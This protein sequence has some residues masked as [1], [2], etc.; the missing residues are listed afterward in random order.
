MG[1]S[2]PQVQQG[3]S[4][5][6]ATEQDGPHKGQGLSCSRSAPG[7]S[8]ERDA[9]GQTQLGN[10]NIGEKS[11]KKNPFCAPSALF[12]ACFFSTSGWKDD[13]VTATGS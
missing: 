6:P 1:S 9:Q 3:S 5:S 13:D 11:N 8:R 12:N 4:A 2:G 10:V 7:S